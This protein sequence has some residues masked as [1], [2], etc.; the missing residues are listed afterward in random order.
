MLTIINTK[1]IKKRGFDYHE[2]YLVNT[3]KKEKISLLLIIITRI[4]IRIII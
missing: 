4:V 1:F 2:Y 3:S